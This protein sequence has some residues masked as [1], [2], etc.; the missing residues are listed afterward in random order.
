MKKISTYIIIVLFC[1]LSNLF[2]TVLNSITHNFITAIIG[3][4]LMIAVSIGLGYLSF[5]V[6]QKISYSLNG[7][8]YKV[9]S[10]FS[11]FMGIISGVNTVTELFPNYEL[12]DVIINFDALITLIS[13]LINPMLIFGVTLFI[14]YR[15]CY[16]SNRTL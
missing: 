9:F 12:V 4:L 6:S 5:Y 16:K 11:M 2:Y 3:L 1:S 7:I 13:S 14:K 10:I 8:R 15:S